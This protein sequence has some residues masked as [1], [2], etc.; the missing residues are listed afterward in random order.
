M[1]DPETREIKLA[2]LQW[3]Y[4]VAETANSHGTTCDECEDQL[5]TVCDEIQAVIGSDP[6]LDET[7]IPDSEGV[8]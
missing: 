8:H 7:H 3:W 5:D 6:D 4:S 2:T 1:S